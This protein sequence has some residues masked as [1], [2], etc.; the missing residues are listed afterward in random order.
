MVDLPLGGAEA[1]SDGNGTYDEV[2][3]DEKGR[4]CEPACYDN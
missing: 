2:D 4:G 1:R 3:E